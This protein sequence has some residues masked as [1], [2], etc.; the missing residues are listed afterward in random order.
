MDIR[1]KIDD[2]LIEWK[3]REG[4][5][6]LIVK[7]A[8]QIG[9]TFSIMRFAKKEYANVVEV[10]FALKPQYKTIFDDGYEVDSILKN[11]SL[12]DT[13]VR[14][15]TGKTLLFFDELQQQPAAATS[16]KLRRRMAPLHR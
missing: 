9:K 12:I 10:N 8:R 5:K 2:S 14:F 11:I 7:G 6:P 3:Q 16:L 15:E 13:N 4:H 1:R